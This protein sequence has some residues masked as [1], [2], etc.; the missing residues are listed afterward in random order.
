MRRRR[1]PGEIATPL[2]AADK[3]VV[4]TSAAC[5]SEDVLR[6]AANV[7]WALCRGASG[8]TLPGRAGV[9]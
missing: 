6:A 4:V 5:A 9:Q 7:A 1:S 8:Q 3:P 2:R